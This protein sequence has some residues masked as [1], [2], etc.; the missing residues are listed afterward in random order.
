MTLKF[1]ATTFPM[2]M[3]KH[4]FIRQVAVMWHDA[5]TYDLRT[6]SIYS[7]ETHDMVMDFGTVDEN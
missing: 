6:G 3:V 4:A 1:G 2:R 5:M 7:Y